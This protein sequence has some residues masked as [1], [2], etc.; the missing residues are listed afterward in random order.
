MKM[1]SHT[2]VRQCQEVVDEFFREHYAFGAEEKISAW[3]STPN[4]LLG[5]MSPSDMVET[6]REEKLLKCIKNWRNGEFP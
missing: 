5:G 1:Y 4:P 6:G 2:I 3:W